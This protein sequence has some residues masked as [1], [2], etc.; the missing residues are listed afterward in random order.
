MRTTTNIRNR[1]LALALTIAAL[2]AGQS[3][4]AQST[5][6][7]TN[8]GSTFTITRSDGTQAETVFYRTVSLTAYAGFHFTEKN[9]SLIFDAGQT[10]KTVTVSESFSNVNA[11]KYQVGTTRTYRFEVTDWAG[12]IL[13]YRDRSM[14]TGTSVASTAFGVKD[15]T[16]NSGTITVTDAGYAQA[17]HSV[18]VAD[19]YSAAA[20]KDYFAAVGAE[21]RMTVSFD[22]RE[23]DDGYQYVQI[24]ANTSPNDANTDI[25]AEDGWPGNVTHARYA[26]GFSIDGN[27]A[28]TYYSYS[29]PL[30]SQGH[31]CGRI[32]DAW[33]HGKADL[34]NQRFQSDCRASDGRLLIPTD[35]SSLYVRLN[36]SGN[37]SDTWYCQNLAAHIQAVETTAPAKYGT[38]HMHVSGGRHIR[39][40]TFYVSLPF[41]EIVTVTGTPTITTS[42]GTASYVTGSGTNVLTF[43]GAI[44]AAVGT[45]LDVT[46]LNGTV[47]DLAGN[48]LSSFQSSYSSD[49][50]EYI[51]W[52]GNG[53]SAD[54]Y[55]ISSTADLDQLAARVN[56]DENFSGKYFVQGADIAYTYTSAWDA[57]YTQENNYTPIGGYGHSFQGHFDGQGYTISGI[58]IYKLSVGNDDRSIGL[59]GFVSGGTVQ[60]VVLR[61][62]NIEADQDIG[63]IVGY[64]GGG[65]VS[66]CLLVNV[67]TATQLNNFSPAE[68][69]FATV[70]GNHSG[71]TVSGNH[72]RDC[73]LGYHVL[74]THG[75]EILTEDINA[76]QN[77]IYALTTATGVSAT[78]VSSE[79]AVIDGTTY[80]AAGSTFTL[81]YQIIPQGYTF[82]GYTKNGTLFE[83]NSFTMPAEDVALA[84]SIVITPWTGS[85]DTVDDPYIILYPSQLDLL[86]SNV[87]SG[88][89]YE[90]KF[91]KLDADITYSTEGLG[92]GESNYTPIGAYISNTNK[93]FRGTFDGDGHTVSGITVNATSSYIGLFGYVGN[94][95]IV[96]NVVLASS[97]F[98]GKN[99]VGGI[100]GSNEGGT[101]QNCRVESTVGIHASA[102]HADSHGGIVGRLRGGLVAGCVSA[103]TVSHD[104]KD[105]CRNYG[106]IIGD[107]SV[108]STVKDCLYTGST[109][110]APNFCGAIIGFISGSSGILTNNY[111]TNGSLGGVGGNGTCADRDGA[112]RARTVTL[113][114]GVSIT[115]DQTTYDV[116]G[117]TAIGTAALEYDGTLYSG[118]G[119]ALTF[120]SDGG[121]STGFSVNGSPILGDTYT[122]LAG[123]ITVEADFTGW[124]GTGSEDD[125]YIILYPA[126]LDLLAIQVN[127]GNSY[128]NTFFKLGTDI[129]YSTEGLGAGESN[130]T[131]IGGYI[132]GSPMLF[133]GSFDGDGHTVSGLIVT[134]TG[135]SR[136]DWYIGLFGQVG[137]G[138][139]VSGTVKNVIVAN[140]TFT[141]HYY[142]GGI[143]GY[144]DQ[145]VIRNCRVESSVTI[146]AGDQAAS[147]HGGIAGGSSGPEAQVVGC[148]SAAV[149]SNNNQNSCSYYGGIVGSMGNGIVRDCLYTGTT[150]TGL[151]HIGGILGEKNGE[152]GT[153]VN[154]YYTAN[155][156]GGVGRYGYNTGL[157]RDGAMWAGVVLSET[158]TS[159]PTLSENDMVV[160]RREFKE[161]VSSTVCLP[162]A[163]D[164]T[165]AA[166]AGKFYTFVGVDKS[167]TDWEV[168]MQEAD[169]SNKVDGALDANTPYLFKPAATGPVLFHG[170]AA[171]TSIAPVDQTPDATQ[172]P[173]SVGWT[174]KGTYERIDWP[175]DPHTVYGFAAPGKA[176]LAEGKF[177]RVKGGNNSYI[178]PFRAY[179]DAANGGAAARGINAA[180][181][182]ELPDVMTVRLI[183]ANGTPTAIGTLDTRTGE[184][185]FGDEW[186]SLDGC[187]L[188]GNPTKSGLYINNGRKIIIK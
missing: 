158:Q 3:A 139:T 179:L 128:A 14:T 99:Y 146:N 124:A 62:A 134:R 12:A 43:S 84:A 41:S 182:S 140:S 154:N 147:Y 22:V 55:I 26:A 108:A 81:G 82:E 113:G 51:L 85:G 127:S 155:G 27:G 161:N 131:P 24:Y 135:D 98:T 172:Y 6:T 117:I 126:Q 47:R 88:T 100:V 145:S 35:L 42:W 93:Y 56:A 144:N 125:P 137:F 70:V 94:G 5:W 101:V 118:E 112:R 186:Y 149:I 97:T 150:I 173:E 31:E 160:F 111:Y 28:S 132:D 119:Q 116:S 89:T 1:V 86:A 63:G 171:A 75:I 123:N 92:A 83:G 167:G 73:C 109:V 37:N 32:A 59:F 103:A 166:A 34:C 78:P 33:S 4:G 95:G 2:A 60:N 122:M 9:G 107:I 29:F 39:G 106:G 159:M 44:D 20:L 74:E 50:V 121:A 120:S 58:R 11:F 185:S 49:A 79:S 152:S 13:A 162:F 30:T 141:G 23:K 36:A 96:R 40:N 180:A 65:T 10:S 143:A 57:V 68:G 80:Y 153:L 18:T 90:G 188:S 87:N 151:G 138:G 61:D 130:Y 71:G 156:L 129:T 157:D 163:I 165:Q 8:S 19:Y 115:G 110:T 181:A 53:T 52:H 102:Q 72:Y 16:I 175:T 174:F 54:P 169:P 133:R 177:F 187:R 184:V 77:D 148:V 69:N 67:R 142:I 17:Y 104:D 76:P 168:I 21:L 66:G 164:A 178:V 114:V 170:T 91:F 64:L 136:S 105:N 15:M 38:G 48:T 7:V 176:D 46:A 183:S 25:G 45:T